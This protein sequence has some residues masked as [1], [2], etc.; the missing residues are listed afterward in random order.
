MQAATR[1]ALELIADAKDIVY[2]T[3]PWDAAN[4]DRRTYVNL[5]GAQQ[6][7]RGDMSCKIYYDHRDERVHATRGR[8]TT[9]SSFDASYNALVEL[10]EQHGHEIAKG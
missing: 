2:S 6:R 9:S 1:N 7:F 4:G 5:R 8:G 3:K 10:L